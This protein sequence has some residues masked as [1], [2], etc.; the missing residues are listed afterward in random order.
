MEDPNAAI[1]RKLRPR[2][3]ALSD[4]SNKIADKFADVAKKVTKKRKLSVSLETCPFHQF[5][6]FKIQFKSEMQLLTDQTSQFVYFR[7]QTSLS[8]QAQ[9]LWTVTKL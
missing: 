4:I 9:S 5:I 6:S 7:D 3:S 2:R 8:A 1:A